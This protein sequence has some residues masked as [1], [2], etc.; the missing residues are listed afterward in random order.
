VALVPQGRHRYALA[1]QLPVF[2]YGTL[3]WPEVQRR[4]TGK[5]F[6]GRPATLLGYRRGLV[7]GETYP[8]VQPA[9]D[10]SV[11]GMLLSGVDRPSL[12]RLDAYEG[13]DYERLKVQVRDENEQQLVPCWLWLLRPELQDRVSTSPFDLARFVERD[14]PAF[15]RN[16][17]GF[18]TP[19]DAGAAPPR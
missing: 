18:Q 17:P 16:Y 19:P 1:V 13:S 8:S 2:V 9:L 10:C 5:I 6:P 4:I 15:L 14:W 3:L 7:R 12:L 11:P